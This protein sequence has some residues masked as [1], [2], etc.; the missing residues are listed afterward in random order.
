MPAVHSRLRPDAVRLAFLLD[1]DSLRPPYRAEYD[2]CNAPAA[3]GDGADSCGAIDGDG[4]AVAAAIV[5]EERLDDETFEETSAG[6]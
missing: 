5:A 6:I 4:V 2:Y 3:G 1:L